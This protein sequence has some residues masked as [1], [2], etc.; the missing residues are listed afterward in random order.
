M[1]TLGVD[2]V[3][4]QVSNMER[5]IEFYKKT[6]NLKFVGENAPNKIVRLGTDRTL[7]SMH[8]APGK[9]GVVDHFCLTIKDFNQDKVTAE[10]KQKGLTPDYNIFQGFYVK[11]PDGVDVQ[12]I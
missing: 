4:V 6:F 2:H 8:P 11:D 5:S 12:M 9:P 3:S 1:E 10:L 7:V